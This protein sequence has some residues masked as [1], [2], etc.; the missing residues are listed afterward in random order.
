MPSCRHAKRLQGFEHVL[1][2]SG[3]VPLIRP[4]TIEQVRDF[5]MSNAAAMTIL[6]AEPS[7]PTGYGRVFRKLKDS[8]S[9]PTKWTAS[10]SRKC[11]R[12]MKPSSARSIP[13]SMPLQLAPLFANIDKLTTDNHAGEFYLTDMAALLGHVGPQSAG[14]ARGRFQ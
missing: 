2:L 9:Q 3:D 11:C 1:V 13:A 8:A 10:L 4:E 5:H 7:D 12:A 6:T 14:I